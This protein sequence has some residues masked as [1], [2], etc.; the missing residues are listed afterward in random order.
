[1][2]FAM[3]CKVTGIAMIIIGLYKLFVTPVSTLMG[4]DKQTP[5][6]APTKEVS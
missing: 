2:E 1:M 6:P 3:V 5:A 4:G